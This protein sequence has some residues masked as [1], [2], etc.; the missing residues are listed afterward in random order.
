MTVHRSAPS[1]LA[2]LLAG[3]DASPRGILV[4]ALQE[5][6]EAELTETIDAAPGQRTPER[7]ARRNVKRRLVCGVPVATGSGS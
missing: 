7:S 1:D 2:A 3:T 6:I 4:T 5:L